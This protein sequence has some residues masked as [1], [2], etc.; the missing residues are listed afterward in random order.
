MHEA[1]IRLSS[2]GAA[3]VYIPIS[4]NAKDEVGIALIPFNETPDITVFDILGKVMVQKEKCTNM[5]EITNVLTSGTY[6]LRASSESGIRT[7]KIVVP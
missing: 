1:Y 7:I 2:K 6:V 3:D 5:D 4:A